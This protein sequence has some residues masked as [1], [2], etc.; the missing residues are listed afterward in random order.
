M[1]EKPTLGSLFAGIGGFDLGFERAGFKTAWQVEIDPIC[2]DVLRER[3]PHARQLEDVRTCLP[4]LE[5]V[6]VIAGGF[7]CQ[8]LSTMGKRQGLNGARSGLF[9]EVVNIVQRLQPTFLILEN[10]PGL[11]NS[12]DGE[13]LQTVLQTLAKCGY[14]G[15][16]RVLDSR[17]FG[18]PTARRRVFIFASRHGYTKGLIEFMGDAITVAEL[19]KSPHKSGELPPAHNTLLRGV[20]Q[21]AINLSASNITA[22]PNGWGEMARRERMSRDN[23]LRRGMD[24]ANYCEIQAAGNAVVPQVAQWIAQKLMK[25]F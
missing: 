11:I 5:K 17:Y 6:D 13:D 3:F 20:D 18:V 9:F 24:E 12:N 25:D 19:Q 21:A 14:V 22:V 4:A 16:W 7:P 23:G 1:N 8:D 15:G 10:V 2:R